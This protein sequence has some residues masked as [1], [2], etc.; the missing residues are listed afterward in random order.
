MTARRLLLSTTALELVRQRTLAPPL[1]LPPGFA[2][3]PT[4][5]GSAPAA[6][7]L[8]REAGV[9]LDDGAGWRVHP[10]VADDLLVL[11]VP[12][13]GV[14]VRAARPGLA[15]QACLALSGPRGAG[16]LRTGDTAVELSA[17]C[18]QDLPRELARVVPAP[19]PGAVP[20]AV[21]EVPLDVL[22]DGSGSRLRGRATG[23]L[24]AA[25]VAGPRADRPAGIVGS[26]EWVW[27]GYGW[28]GLEAL[29]SRGGRP[30]VRLVPVQPGDLGGWV[31]GLLARAAA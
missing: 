14:T 8:L 17:F 28:T 22:L 7:D 5:L 6:L 3:E 23:S 27:D 4:G 31:A 19:V 24:H 9:A 1:T 18:A 29:P 15:S 2:L 25:V 26:V 30:W 20:R 11:A 12:E 13:V 21:E 16:L 10:A